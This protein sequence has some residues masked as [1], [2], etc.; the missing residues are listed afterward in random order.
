M[1]GDEH[2]SVR[3]YRLQFDVH[4]YAGGDGDDGGGDEEPPLLH[5][6][7]KTSSRHLKML[8]I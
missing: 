5:L 3:L 4:D 2:A 1:Y 8:S 7:R 6:T